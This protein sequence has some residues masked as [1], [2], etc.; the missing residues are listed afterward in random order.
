MSLVYSSR[1]IV[2]YN[3]TFARC[4]RGVRHSPAMIR[5]EY[6]L[7]LFVSPRG[8][9]RLIVS[10]RHFVTHRGERRSSS[11]SYECVH[12]YACACHRHSH[13][14]KLDDRCNERRGSTKRKPSTNL[15]CGGGGA[16]LKLISTPPLPTIHENHQ[17]MK[18][19]FF[20]PPF[21]NVYSV[22]QQR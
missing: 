9:S 10:K 16:V 5:G 21:S 20:F 12:I 1:G 19:D 4:S 2:Y 7:L 18:L 14:R 6:C 8:V 3:N 11:V 22:V 17:R 15:T 13:L